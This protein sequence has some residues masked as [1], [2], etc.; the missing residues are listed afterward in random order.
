MLL[1][2]VF[3]QTKQLV[4]LAQH[5]KVAVLILMAKF[6]IEVTVIASSFAAIASEVS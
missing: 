3:G 4:T 6:H 1:G 2:L 5:Q